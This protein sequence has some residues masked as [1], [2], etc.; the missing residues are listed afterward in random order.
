MKISAFIKTLDG[1]T[2]VCRE[3]FNQTELK[4]LFQL[5]YHVYRAS[6]NEFLFPENPYEMDIDAYDMRAYH[7]GIFECDGNRQIA[8][9]S[10][11]LI[12][13]E[14]T[15]FAPMIRAIAAPYGDL[16]DK[17]EPRHLIPLPIFKFFDASDTHKMMS[18]FKKDFTEISETGRFCLHESLQ[19]SGLALFSVKSMISASLDYLSE[20]GVVLIIVSEMHAQM[21]GRFGFE[22]FGH[23]PKSDEAPENFVLLKISMEQVRERLMREET[24][25]LN[26]PKTARFADAPILKSKDNEPQI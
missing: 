1:K 19:R 13:E 12:T 8:V 11:R 18:A 17:I 4:S 9:G 24:L 21:Y 15:R 26:L 22:P 7:F 5:R 10:M 3:P 14:A 20:T 16:L 2:F 6:S 25:R 23:V